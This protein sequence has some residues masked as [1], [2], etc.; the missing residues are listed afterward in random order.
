MNIVSVNIAGFQMEVDIDRKF[1]EFKKMP[2]DQQLDEAISSEFWMSQIFGASLDEASMKRFWNEFQEPA[3]ERA[4][5][6]AVDGIAV[7]NNAYLFDIM[8]E[9]I[10]FKSSRE[11]GDYE[12]DR[13]LGELMAMR[14]GLIFANLVA[15]KD[16]AY[17]RRM[18]AMIE[19]GGNLDG[20]R[21]GEDSFQGQ[22]VREFC[23][24]FANTRRLP[25]KKQIRENL[26]IDSDDKSQ[27]EALRKALIKLGLS[28]LPQT[29]PPRNTPSEI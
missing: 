13:R 25:T 8:K 19:S 26:G 20:S 16:P 1:E 14:L 4:R 6:V 27:I 2:F 5:W 3:A 12:N 10:D 21:S 11:A 9:A 18:E 22:I 28:G 23:Q 15:R 7:V 29:R 17:F 24:F